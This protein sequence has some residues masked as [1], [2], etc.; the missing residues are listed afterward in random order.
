MPRI[1]RIAPNEYIYH[2]L[3][4]GNNCQNIFLDKNDYK[5]Y[6][7]IIIK[8]KEKF[9]FKVY[10]YVLMTNHVHFVIEPTQTGA[11][12]SQI[13]KILNLSDSLYFKAKYKYTGHLWQ[14]RYKSIIISKDNYLLACGRYIELNP[15]RAK[16]VDDPKD[17]KYS[18]YNFYANGKY[19]EIVDYHP[20]YME[21]SDNEKERRKKYIDFIITDM[22]EKNC[23]ANE[24]TK[25]VVYGSKG[26]TEK[27]Y[28]DYKDKLHKNPVGRPRKTVV[29]KSE[30]SP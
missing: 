24:M 5:K 10:H 8:L 27:I 22:H 13:M 20:I 25:K 21:L 28:K 2:I 16:M 29:E 1:A 23:F 7:D 11:N 18:S 30:N 12:L 4:R 6:L 15:V 3:G 26:F 9:K 17:Y 14:D 19:D